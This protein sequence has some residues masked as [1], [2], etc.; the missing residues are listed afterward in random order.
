MEETTKNSRLPMARVGSDIDRDVPLTWRRVLLTCVSYLLFFTDIPRSGLGFKGLAPGYHAATETLY[1]NFGP[2]HYPIIALTRAANGSVEGSVPQA[3]VW[4]YKFDTCSVGLRT[5]VTQ[6]N[7]SDWDPCILYAR[8]CPGTMIDPAP[9]FTMLDNVATTVQRISSMS[10]RV[11]YLF[12][13]NLNDLFSFGPFKER[14]WRTVRTHYFA[15]GADVCDPTARSRP[16]FCEQPW[17]D[18]AALGT[19]P[20]HTLGL[21]GAGVSGIGRVV[22]DIRAKF[23][24]EA[25]AADPATQV[26]DMAIVE[27]TDDLRAWGGGVAKAYSSA[28]DVVTLL[29]VRNCTGAVATKCTTVFVADYRY[30]GGFGRTNTP[31]WYGI[32]HFLR[33]VGQTYNIGRAIALLVGCYYARVHEDKLLRAPLKAK[34]WVTLTTFLRI[35]AQVV[36]YGS[37]FPVTLFAIA[38]LIDSPFLYFTIFMDLGTLNGSTRFNVGQIYDFWVLLT[39][40]MRNVWVL[41]LVTKAILLSIDHRREQSILGFRGYLLP[42]VSFL[43]VLFEVRLIELRNTNLVFVDTMAP[44]ASLSFV[45]ELQT[46]PSDFKFWGV[47]SDLKNLFVS[48]CA[49]YVVVGGIFNQPLGFRT[50]VPYTLLRFCN[51]TMFS[52]SWNAVVPEKAVYLNRVHSQGHLSAARG[53]LYALMHVTWM[54]D[55]LQ[56]LT[57]L[58][59]QPVVFVYRVRAT[60]EIVH[61]A[62]PLRELLRLDDRVHESLDCIGQELL[63]KL[64][65]QERIYCDIDATIPLTWGRVFLA[66]ASYALF[67]TDIPRSGLGFAQLPVGFGAVTESLFSS[68]GP[69]AYPIIGVTKTTD[70]IY[71]GSI[72]MAKVWSYKFDTCSVGLRTV[73]AEHNVAGWPPCLLYRSTCDNTMLEPAI[74]FVMLDDVFSAVKATHSVAWRVS[75]YFYDIIN[76]VFA[77]GTFKE[78]DWRTV[79]THYLPVPSLDMCAPEY[80]TRPFFCEQPWTDFGALGV[81]DTP[82]IMS[83]I[84]SRFAARVNASNAAT[85]LVEVALIEAI[86]DI[87]SWGGGLAK[88]YASAYDVIALLRVRNC[89]GGS[90]TNCSTVFVS[91]YRYEGGLAKTNTMRFYG[92]AHILRLV[93]QTYNISRVIALFVGCYYAR[94]NEEKYLRATQWRKLWV[95]LTTCLRIPA[96]VV[97]HGSWFP[98]TLFAAAHFIDSPL[99]YYTIFMNLGTLNGST[100]FTPDMVYTF[101]ILLTCH[102]RNVWVL[103]LWTKLG[104]VAVDQRKDGSILGFRGY[105]LPFVSFLSIFFE[106]RLTELRRTDLLDVL[107]AAPSASRTLVREFETIPSNYRYWGVFSDVKNLFLSWTAVYIIFGGLLRRRL[108]FRTTVPHSLLRFC[109]RTMFSTSWN[110]VVSDNGVHAADVALAERASLNALMHITWMTDP[111]QYASLLWSQPVVYTYRDKAT[112]AVLHHALPH[113]ELARRDKSLSDSLE[114]LGEVLFMQLPWEER[115]YCY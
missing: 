25:A 59:T 29:R 4:S 51:R 31:Y 76:D 55:P 5:V 80:P 107:P 33:L 21:M 26:V 11:Y 64:P 94:V 78:R 113:R 16:S 67:F 72:P 34:M 35:P 83:D 95:A 13:D 85:Q 60:E 93:G 90:Y 30:E 1:S 12:S 70:G 92:A 97:I 111:L 106:I 42:F 87:R 104:L 91:D 56:H 6:Y 48:W 50:T 10:W 81:T 68:F 20:S 18:F 98:V 52:T 89:T 32:A 112:Q 37:W 3:K 79:R 96:Q 28:F 102:M 23:T 69:Y 40:H 17:V 9:L 8:D 57:L 71:A 43:S 99:L 82:R 110:S 36:I 86:D 77:F 101:W 114:C 66:T 58:W 22:D 75:Y 14:A 88:T 44:S 54:T 73:V 15:A 7:V 38:H 62:L 49:V 84:Q 53:S 46:V 24:A 109:N 74:V 65:W 2:Y 108:G 100:R 103:S 19:F 41:S 45:R 27:A 61:H 47:Y 115:I 105:L 39:C 63:M